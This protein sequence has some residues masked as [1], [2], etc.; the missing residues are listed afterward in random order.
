ML[1]PIK[2][3]SSIL[4]CISSLAEIYMPVVGQSSV[5]DR[6]FLK[7]QNLIEKEI[8]LQEELLEVLGMMDALFAT[9]ARKKPMPLDKDNTDG[10]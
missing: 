2:Q 10:L 9:M 1:N 5:I 3:G 6:Q 4:T 8:D 7:L